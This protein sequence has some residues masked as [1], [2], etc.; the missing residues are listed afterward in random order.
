MKVWIPKR[1]PVGWWVAI[2]GQMGGFM[3]N[4]HDVQVEVTKLTL[5]PL[6]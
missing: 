6:E 3:V 1:S 4:H 2:H 5:L